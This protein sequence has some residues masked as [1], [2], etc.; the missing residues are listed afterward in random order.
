MT[1]GVQRRPGR[2]LR[3]RAARSAAS[4]LQ[5]E[6]MIE[7]VKNEK[8]T[9]TLL[10]FCGPF[11]AINRPSRGDGWP[12]LLVSCR[13]AITNAHFG[14]KNQIFRA[15]SMEFPGGFPRIFDAK[16]ILAQGCPDSQLTCR[17]A[18]KIAKADRQTDQT[19]SQSSQTARASQTE[20][21]RETEPDRAAS[22]P[23]DGRP[24]GG[25]GRPAQLAGCSLIEKEGRKEGLQK[26]AWAR[27][28]RREAPRASKA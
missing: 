26:H 5:R 16:S 15:F 24:P 1:L 6:I 17:F 2:L 18:L 21:D 25:L 20:P 23:E 19:A 14:A 12:R 13:F 8:K 4:E 28:E 11:W 10:S 22:Q 7:S 9:D 3:P 27:R